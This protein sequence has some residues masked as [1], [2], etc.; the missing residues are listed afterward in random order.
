MAARLAAPADPTVS[1]QDIGQAPSDR[2]EEN[3][4][5]RASSV[6]AALPDGVIVTDKT[7]VV[8]IANAAAGALMQCD[9]ASAVGQPVSAVLAVESFEG[10][11]IEWEAFLLER[12]LSGEQAEIPHGVLAGHDGGRIPVRITAAP[13]AG[14]PYGSGGAVIVIRRDGVGTLREATEA[15]S[16]AQKMEAIGLLTGGVAHDFNNLL[17]IIRSGVDLLQRDGLTESQRA[18]YVSAIGEAA[19]RGAALTGQ[20]LAFARRQPVQSG[21]FD[22]CAVL[23]RLSHILRAVAGPGV[24]IALETERTPCWIAASVSAF[25]IAII[26]LAVNA[27]DA[28]EGEG[29]IRISLRPVDQADGLDGAREPGSFIAVTVAD[30]GIGISADALERIF[31]P[32][33]TTKPVGRGTGLGLSQVHA[34]A[35][36]SGGAVRVESHP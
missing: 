29:D 35:R 17:T 24:R 11:P 1:G 9:P 15:L 20:L 7:G 30:S 16:Q 31:E 36:Q 28:I 27:R 13:V 26:N 12:A 6:L 23:Q 18:R 14:E 22:A 33:Y 10:R 4:A 21:S 32:F 3:A 34:F 5:P 19:D 25:E 2:R 8:R